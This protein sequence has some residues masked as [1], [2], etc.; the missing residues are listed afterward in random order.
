M[1]FPKNFLWGGAVAANQCEGAWDADGRGPAQTDMLT[2]GTATTP[3]LL[4]YRLPDGSTGAVPQGRPL[5]DGARLAVLE[6]YRYPNHDGVDFYHRYKE[7][8]A[9]LAEM[10]FKQFRMSIS[11]S[12]IFPTG[13]EQ[14][15]NRAG[16]DFYRRVF[17]ELRAHGIEP[18]VT[19]WHFDTPLHIEEELGGW[20]NRKTIAL[21]D[22]YARTIL[23][24]YRGLV[25]HWLTFNEI[26]NTIAFLDLMGMSENDT[27]YQGAY[28]HLHNKF[29]ASAHAVKMAHEIDA[30]MRVGCM[31]CGIANYPLTPDPDDILA[32]R[33]AWE[34]S[35][36]YCG[37]VQCTGAYPT[38]ATRLWR[39]HDVHLDVTDQDM[40]DLAEGRVD[41]YSFSYY[42]SN[43]VTTH[44]DGER[45]GGNF[46]VG[47]KN[48]Y[49]AYSEW[50]W[51]F[52]PKGLRYY[53]ELM[54][55]RYGIPL[56]VVEN[57]LGAVDELV[58][59]EAGEPVVHD[60]YRIDYLREHIREMERAIEDGVDLMGY[61][62]WGCIDVVSAST[63]E[64]RKRYGFVY[65]D[66]N[67]DG[68]GSLAR[69]RKDSFAW[70]RKV[71]ATNGADLS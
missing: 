54:Y 25:K 13:I 39:E 61:T 22:R 56:M 67:D 28:Q 19:M 26:N 30:E 9:L 7:D 58:R 53:L 50:G 46:V 48:P 65:V 43:C 52:D 24:E 4:T 33:Y 5:P 23:T 68:T 45:A 3:R 41:F 57:G 2:G 51:A 31:I 1:A 20:E 17:E 62:P 63:G 29:V 14:E 16:L 21:F 47:A 27:A 66:L 69:Y 70:Y 49:L 59:N 12:R 11:W 55:D 38:Y 35:I 71:I 37:D 44:A 32:N 36:L 42:M 64:M 6:G 15:P 34:K 18:L 8:I 10:G 40:A 60:G